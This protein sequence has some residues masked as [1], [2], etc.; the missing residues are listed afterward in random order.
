MGGGGGRWEVWVMGKMGGMFARINGFA[1]SDWL[2]W[3]K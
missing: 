2:P 1:S 3:S